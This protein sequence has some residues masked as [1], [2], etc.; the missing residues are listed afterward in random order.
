MDVR[1]ADPGQRFP[2]QAAVVEILDIVVVPVE[3]VEAIEIPFFFE[4][5]DGVDDLCGASLVDLL[6]VEDAA[7]LKQKLKELRQGGEE[8]VAAFEEL[9][10]S[11]LVVPLPALGP[12][13]QEG[14]QKLAES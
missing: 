9:G 7:E 8:A 4:L 10:V 1:I 14:M 5:V 3:K 11:R 13:P 2:R 6:S 12:N